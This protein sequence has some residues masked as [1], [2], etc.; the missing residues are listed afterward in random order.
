MREVLWR[1]ADLPYKEAAPVIALPMIV[2]HQLRGVALYGV[3]TTG[4]DIDED[5]VRSL[6]EV[7]SAAAAAYDHIETED[8]RAR[9]RDL[10]AAQKVATA[11]ARAALCSWF[12]TGPGSLKSAFDVGEFRIR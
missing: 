3:H 4:A 9:L 2:R 5:E 1:N 10:S 6:V 7:T 11:P 8:L 12:L